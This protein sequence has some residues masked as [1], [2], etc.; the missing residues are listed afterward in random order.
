MSARPGRRG[1]AA[2]VGTVV[3]ALT[4]S[5]CSANSGSGSGK[6]AAAEDAPVAVEKVDE[7]AA[8][9]PGEYR[10]S[11]TLVVGVNLPY[12]PNEFKDE[13]G[14]LVGFDVDLINA[15][16]TTLGL[17]VEYQE[18]DFSKIITSVASGAFDVGMSSVTD[19]KEREKLVDFVTYF[20]AGTLWAQRPGSDIDPKNACGKRIGVKATTIQETQELSAKNKACIE[21]GKGEIKI[22]DFIDQDQVNNAVVVGKVDAMTADSP[23]TSYAIEQSDGKL[24][25]AGSTFDSAPYGWPVRKDSLLGE[26]LLKALES[27]IRSGAYKQIAAKWGLSSGMLDK[28]VINGAIS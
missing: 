11:G 15:V 27:V 2:A 24:E 16:T 19:T 28:P 4:L 9:L 17:T 6:G 21:A 20:T 18:A 5:G 26:S 22:F 8:S 1:R 7:I 12:P 14:E 10:E 23:V 13:S 3:V 25:A